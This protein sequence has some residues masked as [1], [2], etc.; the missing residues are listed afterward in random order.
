MVVFGIATSPALLAVTVGARRLA[1]RD[2]RVR[3]ALAVAVLLVGLTS[4]GMRF[5]NLPNAGHS[6]HAG[7]VPAQ[8]S[9]LDPSD[10]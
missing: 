6:G 8:L 9:S 10:G 4:I 7:H 5:G 3:R 1:Y 2:L